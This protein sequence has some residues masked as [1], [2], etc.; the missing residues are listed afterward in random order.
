MEEGRSRPGTAP[1][2]KS[3]ARVKGNQKEQNLKLDPNNLKSFLLTSPFGLPTDFHSLHGAHCGDFHSEHFW[4]QIYY[5]SS[6]LRPAWRRACPLPSVPDDIPETTGGLG[7]LYLAA[8]DFSRL[9]VV[10]EPS[11]GTGL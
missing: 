8:E 1:S 2:V 6:N 5:S 9:V 7:M 4:S 10:Y 11:L 3:G